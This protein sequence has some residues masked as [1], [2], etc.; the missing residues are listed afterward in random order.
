MRG[1]NK[2]S[3]RLQRIITNRTLSVS[4]RTA[5]LNWAFYFGKIIQ[6]KSGTDAGNECN[7][8]SL[9][10]VRIRLPSFFTV[11]V[12]SHRNLNCAHDSISKDAIFDHKKYFCL[13]DNETNRNDFSL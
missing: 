6:T 5:G 1:S 10:V 11:F 13:P 9:L 12:L 4:I 2:Q 7:N 3:F 8:R